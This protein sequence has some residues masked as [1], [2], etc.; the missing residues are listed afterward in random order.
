MNQPNWYLSTSEFA[1]LVVTAIE[2]AGFF[3][4]ND[5]AHPEDIS[6][7]FATV[8]PSVALGIEFVGK[9]IHAKNA[10]MQTGNLSKVLPDDPE[11]GSM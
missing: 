7:A 2:E 6:N 4:R 10:Y 1:A 9:K 5:A 8:A 11:M 3:K